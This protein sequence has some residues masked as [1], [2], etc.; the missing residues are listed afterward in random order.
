MSIAILGD[1]NLSQLVIMPQFREVLNTDFVF[2]P[3]ST[4][5]SFAQYR[6]LLPPGIRY[7]VVGCLSPMLAEYSLTNDVVLSKYF[8]LLNGSYGLLYCKNTFQSVSQL[9]LPSLYTI[10]WIRTL[11]YVQW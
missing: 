8:I 9:N 1:L 4:M 3:A 10:F 7:L 6:T 5:S 2:Y 11:A